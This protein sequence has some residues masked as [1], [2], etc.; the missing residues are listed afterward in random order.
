MSSINPF[1]SFLRVMGLFF[2]ATIFF[3]G[4]DTTETTGGTVSLSLLS[5]SSLQKVN[6]DTIELTE[7]KILL[8][9]IKL[10]K[11][12]GD[13]DDENE[14][15]GEQEND[16]ND[17][18]NIKVGP[19][20]VLLNLNGMTTD[21]VVANIP[22]GFYGGVKFKIHKIQ[23]SE[24]PPDPE[25]KEGDDSSLRYSV[26]VRGLYDSEPFI[27]KSRKPA[28][29]KIEFEPPI[30]VVENSELNLTIVVDPYSWFYK[31]G[32]L[33]NPSDPANANDIDK[34]IKESFKEV[35]EDDDHDGK[36]D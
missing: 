23:G 36:K 19:F 6:S 27:Y 11:E 12:E 26:I 34:S 5:S 18:Y 14:S 2:L 31:D 25:F 16:D 30:E 4:C 35:Y 1:L 24:I 32:I 33:L 28:H 21:F 22:A 3:I 9:D 10:E 29:K 17:S 8:R 13:A 7:V 20:V 15:N